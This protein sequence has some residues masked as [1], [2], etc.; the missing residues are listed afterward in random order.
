MDPCRLWW[1]SFQTF[2]SVVLL[3]DSKRS[4][5]TVLLALSRCIFVG[6]CCIER[7][8]FQW[9]RV[10]G[11]VDRATLFEGR[12]WGSSVPW[13]CLLLENASTV[14]YCSGQFLYLTKC[15]GSIRSCRMER[16]GGRNLLTKKKGIKEMCFF[17]WCKSNVSVRNNGT[18]LE[19]IFFS[20]TEKIRNFS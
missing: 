12:E 3:W 18:F 8:S 20:L 11:P 10:P 4:S 17:K 13:F 14:L 1:V 19:Y 15:S 7:G 2:H 5:S 9:W 6:I 16:G